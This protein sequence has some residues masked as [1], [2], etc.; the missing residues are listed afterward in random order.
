MKTSPKFLVLFAGLL[1]ALVVQAETV[2]STEAACC[3][4]PEPVEVAACCAEEL[5][6]VSEELPAESIYQLDFTFTDDA[7]AE[8]KL[9]EL[10]GQPVIMAMFFAQCGYACP[11]LV[12]DIK[13]VLDQLPTEVSEEVKLLL[14]TFDTDRDSVEALNAY[15]ETNELDDRWTLLRASPADTRTFA[16]VVGVQY[17]KEPSGDFSHSNLLTLLD[18]NGII[19]H[20]RS[21][22]Q[23][24]KEGLADATV[25]AVETAD[26]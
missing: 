24:G 26:R 9:T 8:R 21:G 22:L 11:L 25:R 3:A 13:D 18:H 2:E 6:V 14:V 15:R 5:P 4:E 16:M 19:A 23:G 7:G 20:R 12:H 10:R 17:R 1:S